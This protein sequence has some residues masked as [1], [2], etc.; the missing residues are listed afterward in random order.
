MQEKLNRSFLALKMEGAQEPVTVGSL[1]LE[2]GKQMIS[3]LDPPEGNVALLT[4]WF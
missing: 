3:S 2:N 1:Y 4:S